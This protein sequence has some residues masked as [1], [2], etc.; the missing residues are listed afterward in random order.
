MA[1]ENLLVDVSERI[2]TVTFNRPKSLN[3]LNPAT[4]RELGAA[5]E[6]VSSR[7]DVGA[8]LLTGA[9]EKAFIAGADIPVIK[10][11]STMEALDFALL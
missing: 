5:L 1:Y 3:A 11:F 7:P 9:G 2:A 6:E 8:V 10:D 4:V